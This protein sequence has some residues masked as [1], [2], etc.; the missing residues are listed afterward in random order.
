MSRKAIDYPAGQTRTTHATTNSVVAPSASRYQRR[1]P[2]G[3]ESDRG[4]IAMFF[5]K[6]YEVAEGYGK[7]VD[8]IERIDVK[9]VF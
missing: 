6:L 9:R 4:S 7:G 1:F 2:A 5:V 3:A 8:G